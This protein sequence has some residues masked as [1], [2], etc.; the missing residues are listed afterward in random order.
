MTT[1]RSL[2]VL[3]IAVLGFAAIGCS[4][5]DQKS[6][7][8]NVGAV[9]KGSPDLPDFY[10][11]PDPLPAGKPGQLIKSE[12]VD[13]PGLNGSMSRVMYLSTNINGEAIAVTGLILIPKGTAPS[14]GW[15]II[16]WA[17]GTTGI[18][19]ACAPSLK[20][21][22]FV[23]LA[24]GLLNAGYLV[25]ATDYEGLGTPGRHPY[26]VGESEARG[27]LD[28]VRMAQTFP[29]AN[30]SKRY[31]IWG[32]S[33]GGHAAMFAGHIAKTY[34]PEI[35]LVADVAGAPPSQLLLV[36]A[37]LQTSPYKHYIAMVAAAMN[38]AYGDQKADLTQVLTPEGLDFLNNMDTMCSS[39]L[40]KAAAG[41]DFTKLQKA[42]PSTI[43]AWNQLLK[44]NDPGTFTAPIPVPLLIIHG[45]N[46]E[47]IP[48]VSSAALFDQLC[49][50]GQV[51]QRWVFAGQSHAGVIAPS[52]TSMV[53]WIGDRFTGKPMPDPIAP[54]G[55]VV[56]S[57]PAS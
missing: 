23:T 45:G 34:A 1:K 56:Q 40:G 14:G 51:E 2:A 19:D 25:V 10:G 17:H 5:D 57:C 54:A 9:V 36:N 3:L 30:A 53:S 43:P 32:H 27:T 37:A 52:F 12:N 38:A 28:I 15:P 21:D 41:L 22:E 44:D 29:N 46:D 7:S 8:A 39:D 11:V 35:E 4:S 48:V 42:D 47:Q 16:T 20:P 6:S 55:A 26:I 49:K 31:A 24:N 13:A 18:A 50:I 33:Q